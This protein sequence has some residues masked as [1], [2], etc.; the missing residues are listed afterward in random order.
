M[1]VKY[2]APPPLLGTYDAHAYRVRMGIGDAAANHYLV[3]ENLAI[4]K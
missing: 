2:L 4:D 3:K 1:Y